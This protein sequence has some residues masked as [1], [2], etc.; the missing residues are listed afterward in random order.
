MQRAV[1]Q[2][3]A[4][5]LL[6]NYHHQNLIRLHVHF[7]QHESP[8]VGCTD[9]F[10]GL[11]YIERLWSDLYPGEAL[12]NSRHLVAEAVIEDDQVKVTQ[13][14]FLYGCTLTHVYQFPVASVSPNIVRNALV[15]RFYPK[16]VPHSHEILVDDEQ[17]YWRPLGEFDEH[18]RRQAPQPPS[19]VIRL[20]CRNCASTFWGFR[21]ESRCAVCDLKQ[22]M[23]GRTAGASLTHN[24]LF[25]TQIL[26]PP[27]DF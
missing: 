18:V 6:K 8:I 9:T 22:G 26:H 2:V 25:Q 5:I 19:S 1:K 11:T 14:A 15:D 12:K 24:D 13:C 4:H 27:W 17:I 21:P 20:T 10:T 3:F 7:V 23:F 16:V